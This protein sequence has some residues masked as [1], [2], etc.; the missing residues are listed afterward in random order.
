MG[1]ATERGLDAAK[2]D[3]YIGEQLLQNLGID[4]GGVLGPHVVATVRTIGILGAQ[5][6]GGGVLIDHRVHTA[7]SNAEEQAG[8]AQL[9]EVAVVTMPVGLRNDGHPIACRLQCAS[10]DSHTE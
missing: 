3:G 4:D 10:N 7:R 2:H 1:D 5:S 9:L 8:T 6:A